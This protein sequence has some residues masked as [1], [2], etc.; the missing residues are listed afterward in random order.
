[1]VR[2]QLEEFRKKQRRTDQENRNNEV[3]QIN[4]SKVGPVRDQLNDKMQSFQNSGKEVSY[5]KRSQSCIDYSAA[6]KSGATSDRKE[7]VKQQ[8]K[9]MPMTT[10]N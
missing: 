8:P 1:M 2:Q 6:Q 9:Q 3:R 7:R 10:T 4:A 5:R